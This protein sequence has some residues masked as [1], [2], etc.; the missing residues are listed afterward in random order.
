VRLRTLYALVGAVVG[1]GLGVLAAYGVVIVGASVSWL[2]LFGDDAWPAS[3][4][5]VIPG[6]GVLGGIIIWLSATLVAARY[7][8]SLENAAPEAVTRQRK[9][10]YLLLATSVLFDIVLAGAVVANIRQQDAARQS[11]NAQSA[12]F[13]EFLA[14]RHDIDA[15]EVRRQDAQGHIAVT[16]RTSGANPGDHRLEWLVRELLYKKILAEGETTLRLTGGRRDTALSLDAKALA[17][18]YH[19]LALDGADANVMVD[20]D[21]VFEA[22]LVP[23]LDANTR[24]RMPIHERKNLD[25]GYSELIVTGEAPLPIRFIL[26]GAKIT[27]GP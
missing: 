23:R 17:A 26:R 3:I 2:F 1:A 20:E 4:A 16:L 21:F 9:L 5:W 6:A 25:N 24:N 22:R 10:A 13:A 19:R 12:W 8:R 27:L 15:I 18:A 11:S 14:G 7:G